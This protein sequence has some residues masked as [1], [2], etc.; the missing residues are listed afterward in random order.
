MVLGKQMHVQVV[1]ADLD[2][3]ADAE[4]LTATLEVYRAKTDAEIEAEQIENASKTPA[5]QGAAVD[6]EELIRGVVIA[7]ID[8]GEIT[9]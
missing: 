3:T 5:T 2:L 4:S 6:L 1:D 7:V 8:R 9:A